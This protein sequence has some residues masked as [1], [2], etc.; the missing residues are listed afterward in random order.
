MFLSGCRA[1]PFFPHFLS[2]LDFLSFVV[3]V[4]ELA[5]FSSSSFGN[6][7]F[8]QEIREEWIH[9][10]RAME[11]S[12]VSFLILV[13]GRTVDIASTIGEISLPGDISFK[14][15]M[16]WFLTTNVVCALNRG[17]LV[18]LYLAFVYSILIW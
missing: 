8:T 18:L 16:N 15:G 12:A 6:V 4:D 10:K 9:V 13:S 14:N 1:F 17:F 7:K 2:F 3:F 5:V 11:A